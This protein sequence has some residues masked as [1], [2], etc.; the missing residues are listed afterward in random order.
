MKKINSLEDQLKRMKSLM[1]EER[2]YGNLIHN[3]EK[4]NCFTRTKYN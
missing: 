1:T 3:E 4:K 2:L